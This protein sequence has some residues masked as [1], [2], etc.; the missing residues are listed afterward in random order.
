M[1]VRVRGAVAASAALVVIGLTLAAPAF[2]DPGPKIT[3]Y[4]GMDM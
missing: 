4:A 1:R 2:A 3:R